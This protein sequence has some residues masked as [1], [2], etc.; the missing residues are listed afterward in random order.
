MELG[1]RSILSSFVLKPVLSCRDCFGA[2]FL[3]V[4]AKE[5]SYMRWPEPSNSLC[6]LREKEV[7]LFCV[8]TVCSILVFRPAM[9][10]A[11]PL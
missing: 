8:T 11:R 1:L 9:A 7:V 6:F 4:T 5:C 2:L 10:F 3:R